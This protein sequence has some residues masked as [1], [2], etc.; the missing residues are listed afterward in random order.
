ML[1]STLKL[2]NLNAEQVYNTL[3][4]LKIVSPE[5]A[6]MVPEPITNSLLIY[7]DAETLNVI[8]SVVDKIDVAK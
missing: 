4:R 6:R 5:A 1:L 8:K 7:T 2:K 3:T